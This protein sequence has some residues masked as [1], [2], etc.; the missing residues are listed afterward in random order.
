MVVYWAGQRAV[1]KVDRMDVP[2]AV[3]LVDL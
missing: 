1:L 2:W 3:Y